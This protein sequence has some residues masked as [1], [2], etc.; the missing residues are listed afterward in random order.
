VEA[1]G[2]GVTLFKPG[3]RV[4]Y[5]G[6]LKR[7]GSNSDYQLVDERITGP[8]PSK[9]SFTEAAAMPLTT[10]TAWESLF[11]RMKIDPQRDAGKRLLIIGAAGGVGS[12]AIQLA[13]SLADLEV[14]ATASRSETSDWC[15]SL[16]ADVVINHRESLP[17]QFRQQGIEAPDYILCLNDTDAYF[18]IMAELVAPQGII[19]SLVSSASPQDLNL[20]K[21]KSVGFVWEF[22]FT[23][24]SYHTADMQRQHELLTEVAGLLDSGA[25]RTTMQT[26]LGAMSPEQLLQA[27]QMLETGAT[28][29]KIVL[30]GFE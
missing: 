23:R 18:P 17:E 20:L 9:L 7:P 1:V 21:S 22:M 19:C 30:G 13:K 3:D 16:G 29:G 15:R 6:D 10:I 4:F 28:I 8:C 5:A 26:E 24:S 27:H 25:L 12:I 11:D 2:D 14:I